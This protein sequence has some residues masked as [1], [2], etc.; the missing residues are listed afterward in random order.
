MPN[1]MST[2]SSALL[3]FQ[4][5]LSTIGHNVANANTPGYSRQRVDLTSRPGQNLGSGF[6]GSG[7]QVVSVERLNDQFLFSRA[8]DSGSEVGRLSQLSGYADR[9]DAN[10]SDSA[11][12][13]AKPWSSFF[14]SMQ[15]VAAEPASAAARQNMLANAE[16]LASRFRALDGELDAVD[17]E[18]GQR[19]VVTVDDV[20]RLTSEIGKLNQEIARQR[21]ASGG[22]PPNDLLDQRDRLVGELNARV[23]VTIAEQDDGS[24]NVYAKGGQALV[25]GDRAQKLTLVQDEFRPERQ[26]VALEGSGGTKI[27]MPSNALG[28]ALGGMIEFRTGTLD[29]TAAKLGKL[30]AGMANE[31]NR[32]HRQGMDWYGQMGGDLFA[33]PQPGVSPSSKNL[34]SGSVAATITDPAGITGA[35]IQMR[36]D[37]AAWSAYDASTGAAVA[38]TGSGTAVDPFR[39]GGMSLVTGGAPSA[40][41][42]F[43]VQPTAQASGQIKVAITDPNKIA[44]ATPMKGSAALGNLGSGKVG[45]VKVDDA[46][47]AALLNPVAIQFTG[48]NTY[49]ING[50]GSY[51]YTS[52]SP[53]SVNGWQIA[54][55]GN[56]VAGDT[57]NVAPNGPRASDNGNARNL[58]GLSSKALFDG[59]TV[60]LAS[61]VSQ[62]TSSVGSQARQAE[63]ALD[64][65]TA[66]DTQINGQREAISGVNLD[67]EAANMLKFQ[68]AYQ[69]AAQV[70]SVADQVFQTLL[71]AVRR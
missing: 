34:G 13:I 5:A 27:R 48:P 64:A 29:A 54:I 63:Y 53:I 31:F 58:A 61:T 52:G 35:D 36:Y 37:G 14:D 71:G 70:L 32:V 56:P 9:L 57:F 11:T 47:N 51:P 67:E 65:Q 17:R 49:S 43:L 1:I 39:V 42:A 62:I 18:I 19:M 4:R 12:G 26:T 24:M 23:G 2:G 10:F 15:A 21:G 68:Q 8:L 46:T 30:A 59:G 33:A 28:G 6:I 60:S 20:N 41:D 69:A 45:A 40:G 22:Q 55:E 44:A 3:A 7:V 66:I 25:V 50:V 16:T 38:M